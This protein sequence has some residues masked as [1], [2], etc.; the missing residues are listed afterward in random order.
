[1]ESEWRLHEI[2]ARRNLIAIINIVFLIY[3]VFGIIF[4]FQATRFL[5]IY[6]IVMTI[7]LIYAFYSVYFSEK[8]KEYTEMSH[9]M[10]EGSSK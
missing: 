10:N 8:A 4:T 2:K 7:I 6:H 9:Q 3:D 1:L 5:L